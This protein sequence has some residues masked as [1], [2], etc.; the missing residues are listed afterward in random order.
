MYKDPGAQRD[1]WLTAKP[2]GLG[3]FRNDTFYDVHPQNEYKRGKAGD[4]SRKIWEKT[5]TASD[6]LAKDIG[7]K[8]IKAK[9]FL[10]RNA[11]YASIALATLTPSVYLCF[12]SSSEDDGLAPIVMGVG[13]ATF[14]AYTAYRSAKKKKQE[15]KEQMRLQS[16]ILKTE[17]K[18]IEL[19]QDLLGYVKGDGDLKERLGPDGMK[20]L[21]RKMRKLER[22]EMAVCTANIKTGISNHGD[23]RKHGKYEDRMVA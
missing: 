13:T 12:N 19:L 18:Q 17:R 10:K 21:E 4:G 8:Y 20:S 15:D 23:G 5:R 14:T 7:K 2:Y 9:K 22:K 1:A 16:E 3:T 11:V 6:R